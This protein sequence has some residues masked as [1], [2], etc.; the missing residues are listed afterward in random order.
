[1]GALPRLSKFRRPTLVSAS[2]VWRLFNRARQESGIDET[3]AQ[4]LSSDLHMQIPTL[5]TT[6]HDEPARR[7]FRVKLRPL[8]AAALVSAGLG[9]FLWIQQD[10]GKQHFSCSTRMLMLLAGGLVL[11]G[12]VLGDLSSLIAAQKE[13]APAQEEAKEP[14][15][16]DILR[17]A[18]FALSLVCTVAAYVIND[19]NA[20]K[21]SGVLLWFLAIALFLS[22]WWEPTD[23]WL[24]FRERFL[25]LR[26]ASTKERLRVLGIVALIA[27]VAGLA[28]FFRFHRLDGLPGSAG[29]IESDLANDVREIVDGTV[30]VFFPRKIGEG[31]ML[32]APAAI[33]K[34]FHVTL[35]Y[36]LIKL[37][38]ATAGF[39]AVGATYLLVKEAFSSRLTG[40]LSALFMAVAFW[41]V[42]I[43][44]IALTLTMAPLFTALSL[45]FLLRA[46]RRGQT[47]DFLLCGL[48]VGAGLYFYVGLRVVPILAAACVGMKLATLVSR[49]RWQES[50]ALVGRGLLLG[51]MAL[52]V[53]TPMA[54]AWHDQPTYYMSAPRSRS[55]EGA[56]DFNKLGRLGHNLE[57]AIWMFN[58]AGDTNPLNNVPVRRSLDPAMGAFLLGG[59]A[60][61]IGGWLFY[62]RGPVPYLLLGFMA[63]ILPSVLVLAFPAEV[64]SA[65]RT[66]G[67]MPLIFGVVAL[68]VS[69]VISRVY[70]ALAPPVGLAASSLLLVGLMVPITIYNYKWYFDDYQTSYT[71]HAAHSAC[72]AD[73]IQAEKDS[74]PSLRMVYYIGTPR[75][76]DGGGLKLMLGEPDWI[77]DSY[78]VKK[79]TAL[80]RP[81]SC[82]YV[83][84]SFDDQSL[85]TLH[86][87]FPNSSTKAVE[88]KE[89]DALFLRPGPPPP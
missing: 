55:S 31:T 71:D 43:S 3:T 76:P 56:G 34:F 10:L 77:A 81:R 70:R 25:V 37:P 24:E 89:C 2:F 74:D 67:L 13:P 22:V 40:L 28:A 17:I 39:L 6:Q 75:W 4:V 32:Y 58:W 44:R 86:A 15:R 45:L 49:Q 33:V 8:F 88:G 61:A 52:V 54:R 62:R 38:G 79:D 83:V 48:V 9:L 29:G 63:L 73:L 16:W 64:P 78:P 87:L 82:M 19:S 18:F 12:A 30:Y 46:L 5:D 36:D 53:F 47:N 7:R 65:G 66:A 80:G 68:P 21:L 11:I 20:F 59:T 57:H 50:R 42:T 69:F 84:A 27:V 23:L 41:P 60:I 35:S 85:W 26:R 51:I 1:M 14:R 72:L